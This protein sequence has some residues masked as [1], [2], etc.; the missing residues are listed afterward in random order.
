MEVDQAA[1]ELDLYG[2]TVLP[3]VINE[4]EASRIGA[5]LDEADRKIGIDYA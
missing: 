3:S 2:F 1:F 4:E 5:I